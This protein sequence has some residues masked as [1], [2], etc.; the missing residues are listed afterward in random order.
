[1]RHEAKAE[2]KQFL[3][4]MVQRDMTNG[5]VVLGHSYWQLRIQRQHYHFHC[6]VRDT[7]FFSTR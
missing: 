5:T 4:W 2:E 7:C 3:K 1:M 6:A